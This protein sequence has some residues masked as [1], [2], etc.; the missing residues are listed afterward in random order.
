VR[1]LLATHKTLLL[2]TSAD[3]RPFVAPVYFAESDPF[4]LT[5]IVE[6]AGRSLTNVALNPK[7]AVMISTGS[8]FELYLQGEGYAEVISDSQQLVGAMNAVRAKAPEVELLKLTPVV[9][10]VTIHHWQA[11]DVTVGWR[12]TNKLVRP[13]EQFPN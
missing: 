12:H 3:D 2:S 9:V 6:S 5:I 8:P 7:V 11:T 4:H 10:N 1:E 13:A